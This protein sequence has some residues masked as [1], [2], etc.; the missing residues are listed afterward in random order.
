MKRKGMALLLVLLMVLSLAAC[1]EAQ[2]QEHSA[3]AG[4]AV[5]VQSAAIETISTDVTV[6]GKVS[7]ESETAVYV[8]GSNSAK[9]TAV[10]V[11]EG[12]YVTAGDVLCTLDMSGVSGNDL[13]AQASYLSSMENYNTQKELLDRQVALQE[14]N[15]SDTLALYEIGAASQLEVDAA[16]LQ[17]LSAV[18]QRDATLAQLAAGM[19]S[20]QS[21]YLQTSMA[22]QGVDA[23]G[24]VLAPIS[25]KVTALIA[26]VGG[27]VSS[28]QPVAVIDATG[29]MRVSVSVSEALVPKLSLGDMASVHISSLDLRFDAPIYSIDR[30]ASMQT[31]LYGVVLSVPEEIE[32]LRS[33]IFADVSF[34]TETSVEAVVVPTEAI[35][36][37][38]TEKYVY[39]VYD[40]AAKKMA[41]TTGLAGS[42]VTEIV[43]GVEAGDSVV[44]VG[45]QYL[46]D[47]DAVRVVE[48]TAK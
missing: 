40:G 38:N 26:S 27:T 17:Y 25:G 14:K 42:G 45:Q 28:A 1:G 41:V 4:V 24:N 9:C 33:G 31:Q 39:V 36:T 18:A 48:D 21:G 30:A 10:Y 34:H 12:D 37:S 16:E 22:M 13:N 11:S 7:A 29:Q 19:S 47:G 6:S 23:A 2:E 20:S 46:S 44:T 3:P 8:L 43:S 35:L 32:G 5:Q 15:F